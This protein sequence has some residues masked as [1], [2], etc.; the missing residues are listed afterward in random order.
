MANSTFHIIWSLSQS[1]ANITKRGQNL[2][3]TS[4][5]CMKYRYHSFYSKISCLPLISLLCD[6]L[7]QNSSE[8]FASQSYMSYLIWKSGRFYREFTFHITCIIIIDRNLSQTAQRSRVT[9][10]SMV[11]SI[12]RDLDLQ[13][14]KMTNFKQESFFKSMQQLQHL[15]Y[16][17]QLQTVFYTELF[18]VF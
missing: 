10:K 18:H 7:I 15:C 17:F 2:H 14:D 4:K 3:F 16:S 11:M 6:R 5:R 8:R 9:V 12:I 13:Y 1:M